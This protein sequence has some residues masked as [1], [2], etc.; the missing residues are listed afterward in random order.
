MARA[1]RND[2]APLNGVPMLDCTIRIALGKQEHTQRH[3]DSKLANGD[4]HPSV[5][6][7][8]NRYLLAKYRQSHT[9]LPVQQQGE[10]GDENPKQTLTV[11]A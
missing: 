7:F 1:D 9:A 4:V 8:V 11:A 10:T 2:L 5:A 6:N 3:S